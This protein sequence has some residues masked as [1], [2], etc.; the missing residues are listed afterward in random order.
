MREGKRPRS[1]FNN[2]KGACA[3]IK[4]G[5]RKSCRSKLCLKRSGLK[6]TSRIT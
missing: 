4:R 2:I 1:L 5:K 3:E 6:K